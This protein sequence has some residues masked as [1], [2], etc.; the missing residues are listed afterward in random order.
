MEHHHAVDDVGAFGLQRDGV[1]QFFFRTLGE[2]KLLEQTG[3]LGKATSS[4]GHLD[5]ESGDLGLRGCGFFSELKG[6]LV[7]A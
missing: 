5:V 1:I 6:K 4:G 7:V 2:C 3:V